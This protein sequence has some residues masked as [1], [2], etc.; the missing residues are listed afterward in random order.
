[1]SNAIEFATKAHDGQKRKVTG[2]PSILHS[3]EAASVVAYITSDEDVICAA[4]LHDVAEDTEY[5]LNDIEKRFGKRVAELVGSETE[6]K[7]P[8][9]APETTWKIRKEETLAHLR[10]TTDKNVKI[11]WLGDKLS[12]IRSIYNEYLEIG[13]GVWTNFHVKDKNLHAWYYGSVAEILK[14]DFADSPFFGEY[15]RL[16]NTIFGK[17]QRNE[18]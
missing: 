3:L 8:S 7:R 2:V 13:D 5:T 16:V 18:Q 9:L 14:K 17:E 11:L 6:N 1:M 15:E 4:V 12:N 10:Q